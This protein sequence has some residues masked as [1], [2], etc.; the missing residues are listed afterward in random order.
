MSLGVRNRHDELEAAAFFLIDKRRL[1]FLFGGT[2]KDGRKSGAMRLIFDEVIRKHAGQDFILDFEGSSVPSVAHFYEGF[3]ARKRFFTH[4]HFSRNEF[5][6][7]LNQLRL[8]RNQWR[9]L[10]HG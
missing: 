10:Y 2:S 5:F 1:I 4:L 9:A 3:G 6:E 8:I 7:W